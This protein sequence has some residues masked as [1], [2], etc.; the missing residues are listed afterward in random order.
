VSRIEQL[1]VGDA[2]SI[3]SLSWSAGWDYTHREVVVF[4]VSGTLFGQR[5]ESGRIVSCAGVFSYGEMASIGV[6]IVHPEYQGQGLGR[7]LMQRCLEEVDHIPAMLVSTVEGQ[8]LYSSLGF[9]TVSYI[10]KLLYKQRIRWSTDPFHDGKLTSLSEA[11]LLNVIQLDEQVVGGDRSRFLRS[12]FPFLKGGVVLTGSDG[13]LRGYAMTVYRNDLLIVGP[14]VAPSHDAAL[15]MIRHLT[16][17]W[18][19]PVRIDVPSVQ[20][21]LFNSFIALGMHEEERPP[22]MMRNADTLPG[23]RSRLYAIAAQAFG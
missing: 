15:A 2:E 12:R 13:T 17:R 3:L 9:R 16:V 20:V 5:S 8:R 10:H 19:G 7:A 1:G 21:E 6:V 11:D 18:Q 14:V 4:L 23:D 22:V